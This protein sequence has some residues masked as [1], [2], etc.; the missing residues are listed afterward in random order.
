MYDA[1]LTIN[2]RGLWE[3]F[4]KEL[5]DEVSSLEIWLINHHEIWTFFILFVSLYFH[6]FFSTIRNL[7]L[8]IFLIKFYKPN[9]S[10]SFYKL[11]AFFVFIIFFIIKK[12]IYFWFVKTF[13]LLHVSLWILRNWTELLWKIQNKLE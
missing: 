11:E 13:F 3:I 6:Y 8:K 9:S 7:T 12:L 4:N 2:N 1:L 10:I 5:F